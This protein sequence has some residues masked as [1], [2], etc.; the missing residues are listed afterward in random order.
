MSKSRFNVRTLLVASGALAAGSGLVTVP[1]WALNVPSITTIAGTGAT[2]YTGDG[3]LAV[4]AKLNIPTGIAED[5]AGSL[6]FSDT[7]NNAVRKIVSPTRLNHDT[8]TTIAGNGT[9]GFSGDGGPATSAQLNRPTGTAVDSSGNVYISDTGNNRVRKIALNGTITTLAGS[10]RCTSKDDP[11]STPMALPGDGGPATQASLCSPTGVAVDQS[12][13]VY[14]ADTNH[15][16]VRIVSNAGIITTFAG[17]G[18]AG[19]S[20]DGGKATKATLNSPTG[21]AV[22][23][24][25]NVYIADTGNNK[26]RKV[27]TSG[28]ISTFAGTGVQGYGG[29]GG[30]ATSAQM[31]QPTGLGV[32]PTGTVYIS[33]TGNQRVRRVAGSTISTYGGNGTKGFSGDGG[34]ASSAMLNTP[35]G[36]VAADGSAVY[37]SDT[38]NQRVRGIFPSSP[39]P[40]LPETALA[41]GLPIAGVLAG[42][43]TIAFMRRRRV[44][45]SI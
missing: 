20:G 13:N 11:G 25:K 44:R 9:A 32:D 42:G 40:V 5:T 4:N 45:P 33:D 8:I 43:V 10:G 41:V 19:S 31:N 38:G 3:G 6:Y 30:A 21:V 37:F 16:A 1:A 39:P 22:D 18:K 14:I 2:G 26:V 15:N 34:A 12:G 7:N 23:G 36:A 28:I 29:D 24:V 35:T 17:Y 27:N